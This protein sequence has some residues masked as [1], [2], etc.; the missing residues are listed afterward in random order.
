MAKAERVFGILCGDVFFP[1]PAPDVGEPV[2]PTAPVHLFGSSVR[3]V[4]S[5]GFPGLGS[6][7]GTVGDPAVGLLS[8]RG[9]R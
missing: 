2:A 7:G 4:C 8:F 6:Q 9:G 5:P 1:Q 3:M